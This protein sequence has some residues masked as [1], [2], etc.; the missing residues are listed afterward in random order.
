VPIAGGR[1]AR[2]VDALR[3]QQA[4]RAAARGEPRA[5][6]T[7]IPEAE[8]R[9]ILVSLGC[10]VN[11]ASGGLAVGVPATR[12][13]LAI[14]ADLVEEVARITGYHR[15]PSAPMS[16]EFAPPRPNPAMD[17]EDRARDALVACGSPR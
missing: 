5:L 15:I 2:V 6:G 17:A 1:C 12:L 3:P 7:R 8:V 14:P 9:R 11:P 16:G 10:T 4:H 13:D